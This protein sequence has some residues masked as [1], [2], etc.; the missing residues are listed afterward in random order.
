VGIGDKE[1]FY[2]SSSKTWLEGG[3][4]SQYISIIVHFYPKTYKDIVKLLSIQERRRH[5]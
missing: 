4:K 2:L 3:R 1:E 5:D